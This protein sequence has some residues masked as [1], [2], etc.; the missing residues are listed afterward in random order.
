MLK[1]SVLGIGNAGNQIANLAIR[2]GIDA[3][4]VNT[5]EKDLEAIARDIPVY[6]LGNSEGAGKDRTVAKTFVK[7]NYRD[8]LRHDNFN[9]FI[10][11]QDIVFVVASTGGGT[12]S[13]VSIILTDI[14]S[15]VY[16]NKLFI[17]IGILPTLSDSIGSQ[18]NTLEFLKE[19]KGMEMGYMLYDNNKYKSLTPAE[20]ME[21]VNREIIDTLLYIRG[22]YCYRTQYGMIDD[23]D[24]YK[25]L[26]VSGMINVTSFEN[27]FEKDMENDVT[28]DTY[29]IKNMKTNATCQ[30]DKDRIIKRMGIIANLS[31]DLTRYYD[32]GMEKFKSIIGEPVEV[33]EHYYISENSA[34][35]PNKFAVIL[36]GLSIPDDRIQVII[37][38]IVEVEAALNKT[39]DS[40]LLDQVQSLDSLKVRSLNVDRTRSSEKVNV[41][42]L[43]LDFLSDRY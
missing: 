1:I 38:R 35:V 40:S 43:D 16:P 19:L 22:D 27:F 12:G 41:N 39:K 30:I 26:T 9:Q 28:L 29:I 17:N 14:L 24:M 11:T 5:S 20:Y 13:G 31:N 21:K 37:Q 23:A 33:F 10:A 7:Q 34:E 32:P 6:L 3:F 36:A 2:E 25:L 18:R 8:L 4:C 15:R 42:D